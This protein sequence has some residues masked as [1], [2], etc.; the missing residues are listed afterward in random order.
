MSSLHRSISLTRRTV[1]GSALAVAAQGASAAAAGGVAVSQRSRV[2][3]RDFG[4]TGRGSQDDTAALQRAH[5]VAAMVYYPAGIYRFSAL[6]LAKGGIIGDGP[7]TVLQP[8]GGG[9]PAAITHTGS[10][11][12]PVAVPLF[13][14]FSIIGSEDPS[15]PRV[16]PMTAIR[17]GASAVRAPLLFAQVENVKFRRWR[18]CIDTTNASSFR[19][20][21]C[22]FFYYADQALLVGNSI[23]G[24]AGD[25]LVSGC[26]FFNGNST[27][28]ALGTGILQRSSG[29]LRVVAN[30]FNGGRSAYTM[31]LEA[32][33]SILII[34]ANS[35]EHS[36]TAAIK[37][38]NRRNRKN[39]PVRFGQMLITG[40]QFAHNSI[41]IATE[42]IANFENMSYWD[43][44][45]IANNVIFRESTN[46]SV[47]IECARDV[48][49]SNNMF[50]G[51]GNR[52]IE[53]KPSVTRI[54]ID[55]LLI[56]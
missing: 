55:G 37:M 10:G 39:A 15:G 52:K 46:P 26:H 45:L 3:V 2:D 38:T 48:L 13:R 17:I 49:I 9:G 56:Q 12:D 40:N 34:E 14:D 53:L 19:I 29:G 5:D 32:S 41:D 8:I 51:N 35:I 11:A 7:S 1:L 47:Y 44:L 4:V 43:G 21:N 20:I 24:D 18:T 27:F 42:E 36:S 25:S 6:E 16:A 22:D 23:D 30:K 31:E 33:T 54:K 28:Q 50:F